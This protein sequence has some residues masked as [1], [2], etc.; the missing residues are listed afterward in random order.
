V[1]FLKQT[2][3]IVAFFKQSIVVWNLEDENINEEKKTMYPIYLI[4]SIYIKKL[5]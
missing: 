2:I 4:K 3:R 1:A 5:T